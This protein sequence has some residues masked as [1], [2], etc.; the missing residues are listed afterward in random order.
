MKKLNITDNTK[1][2]EIPIE[3]MHDNGTI[4]TRP[5]EVLSEWRCAYE[6]MLNPSSGDNNHTSETLQ[7]AKSFLETDPGQDAQDVTPSLN[8]P[9]SLWEVAYAKGTAH[10]R[11]ATGVDC[12]PAEVLKNPTMVCALHSLYQM[13][14]KNNLVPES[15]QR[16]I[17]N[18]V[19]KSSCVD[20]RDP[21]QYRGISLT[22]SIYK[23]YCAIL[24]SRLTTWT[25][26]N[27]IICDSQNGFR[28][29]RKSQRKSTF[30]TFIDL[31]KAYDRIDRDLLSYKIRCFGI[32][33]QFYGALRAIYINTA[34]CVRLNN[35]YQ[36]EWFNV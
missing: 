36:T 14:F 30:A 31:R 18:P 12:I 21:L 15:W 7:Q 23:I 19:P 3:I 27:N 28:M 2:K 33:G 17:I 9:I 32:N 22:S 4:D 35:V 10:K 34:S 11:K 6:K 5:E 1:N 29:G 25:E 13:C 8:Q 20:A 26:S 16:S 24:N